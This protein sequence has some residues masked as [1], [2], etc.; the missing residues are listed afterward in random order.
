MKTTMFMTAACAAVAAANHNIKSLYQVGAL[1]NEEEILLAESLI[2]DADITC[3]TIADR[4]K[5]PVDDFYTIFGK[6]AL[7]KDDD[8]TNDAS[9]LAWTSKFK[10]KAFSFATDANFSWVRASEAFPTSGGYSLFGS[11]GIMPEDIRQ[12]ELGNCYFLSAAS[13]MA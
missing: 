5:A 1:D 8:F 12:G 10:E 13:I 6:K 9:S 4:N 11:D 3:L 2:I 7:Y